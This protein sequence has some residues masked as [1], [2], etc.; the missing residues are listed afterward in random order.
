M[1]SLDSNCLLKTQTLLLKCDN[2][3]IIHR[4]QN[5]S[6]NIKIINLPDEYKIL[7]SELY[8]FGYKNLGFFMSIIKINTLY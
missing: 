2:N 5:K 8:L 4:L 3:N 6:E 7:A 1:T